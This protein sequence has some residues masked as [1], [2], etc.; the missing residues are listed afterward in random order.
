MTQR[1]E[2]KSECR[3][4]GL[5]RIES[6]N[7]YESILKCLDEVGDGDRKTD[8]LPSSPIRKQTVVV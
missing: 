8:F 3:A 6:E 1:E 5:V 2:K 4:K 7:S